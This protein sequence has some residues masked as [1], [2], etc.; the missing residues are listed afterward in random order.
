MRDLLVVLG[1]LVTLSQC[2]SLGLGERGEPT[3]LN[4]ALVKRTDPSFYDR[5]FG[6]FGK[7]PDGDDKKQLLKDGIEDVYKLVSTALCVLRKS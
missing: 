1:V 5:D 4:R 2:R 3:F 6:E 7:T